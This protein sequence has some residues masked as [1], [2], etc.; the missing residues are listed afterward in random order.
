[1]T[2]VTLDRGAGAAPLIVGALAAVSM[3]AWI[4]MFGSHAGHADQLQVAFLWMAMTVG[5][6][7]PSAVPMILTYARVIPRLDKSISAG[8]SVVIFTATYLALWAAFAVAAAALQSVMQASLLI[9]DHMAFTN[10]W[11]SGLFLIAA[12]AYQLT[13]LK[14]ICISKCRSPLGFL[15]GTHRP[16]YGGAFVTGLHHGLFC[17]GCCWLL[18]AL[19]WVGGMMNVAWMAALSVLVIVEK[20]A[21]RADW[22]IKFAGA[23]L[24]AAGVALLF[25]PRSEDILILDTLRSLCRGS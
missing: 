10:R 14:H 2:S 21:P 4:A 23:A 15:M 13:S 20:T 3:F 17:I 25:L 22:L 8:G 9:D 18:M 12:G 24:I 11:L 6:M 19:V 7:T 5:M 1:M 16:G